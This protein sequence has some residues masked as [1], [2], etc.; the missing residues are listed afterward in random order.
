MNKLHNL[1]SLY[2]FAVILSGECAI[3]Q[4]D[5]NDRRTLELESR[6]NSFDLIHLQALGEYKGNP[7]V[8]FIVGCPS[9][10]DVA[11]LIKLGLNDFEQESVLIL[12]N[13]GFTATLISHDKTEVIGH[14]LVPIEF[15]M[16]PD[17]TNTTTI[18]AVTYVIL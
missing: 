15:V 3:V 7:E 14:N 2:P 11:D 10:T 13:K 1:I 5:V 16:D 6:L 4:D 9:Y 17:L 18:D 8:S 12:D